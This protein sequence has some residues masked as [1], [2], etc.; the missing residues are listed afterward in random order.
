MN[1]RVFLTSASSSVAVA[2]TVGLSPRRA[3]AQSTNQIYATSNGVACLT[4][5]NTIVSPTTSAA[6]WNAYRNTLIAAA[7]D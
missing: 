2:A 3:T 7:N 6:N 1:R 5:G 4:T